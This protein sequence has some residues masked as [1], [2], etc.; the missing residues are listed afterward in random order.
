MKTILVIEDDEVARELMRMALE[1]RGYN[2][3]VAEDGIA[4]YQRALET[5]PDLIVTDIKM[6]AA[7]GVHLVRRVRDAPELATTPILVTTGFGSGSA[8]FALAQG[9]TAYE[10]KPIDPESFMATVKRLLE[11]GEG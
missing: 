2:V 6:P 5:V 7:D 10:P 9:A 4:G 11:M 1:R 8:T 3:V